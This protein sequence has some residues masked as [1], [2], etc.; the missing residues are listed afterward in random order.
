MPDVKIALTSD[1]YLPV[2][3]ADK[4]L[5]VARQMAEFAPDAAVLAG[6][7]ADSLA[8]FGRV[9]TLFRKELACPLYVLPGDVDFWARPPYGSMQLWADLLP[10]AV[11]K[12][13]CEW[14]EGTAA[15]VGDVGLTGSVA[16]YDYST[17]PVAGFLTDLEFAQQKYQHNA[18]A[19]R[20]DWEWTDPEFAGQVGSAMLKA[21]DELE[22]NSSVR[23]SV[24]VTHFPI[25]E[26]QV[27]RLPGF[28]GAYAGN[29]TL[30]KR[31]LTRAK[32]AHVVSGHARVAR[33]AE[34]ARDGLGGVEVR[35]LPGDYEKPGWV[36]LTV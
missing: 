19:L 21:L 18:D 15:V 13:G 14:L 29:L 22:A 27:V 12:A 17:A 16:W 36:G 1:L 8:D 32:V 5:A 7:L 35:V 4:L 10:R 25:L 6:D 33:K 30:G 2:T 31:V 34:V 20:I 26:P 23:A 28:A 9:L 11:E 3:P 24:V